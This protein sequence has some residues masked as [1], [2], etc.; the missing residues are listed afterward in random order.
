METKPEFKM[1][2]LEA[3]LR[4][5]TKT[6]DEIKATLHE[7]NRFSSLLTEIA[8]DQ[9]NFAKKFEEVDE[10]IDDIEQRQSGNT[11][12]LNKL[13]GSMTTT[14]WVARIVQALLV[15]GI[16]WL[17]TTIMDT[18]DQIQEVAHQVK[19]LERDNQQIIQEL[20]R[21]VHREVDK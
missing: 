17:Y 20:A 8:A 21:G 12:F 11:A 4:G 13:R 2:E 14:A 3:E 1:G 5:V 19:F 16:G 15:A 6:L 18:R 9:K 10:R 7:M